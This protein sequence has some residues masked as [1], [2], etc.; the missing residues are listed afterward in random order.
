[1]RGVEAIKLKKL[2]I[3]YIDYFDQYTTTRRVSIGGATRAAKGGALVHVEGR[4]LG[5][6]PVRSIAHVCYGWAEPEPRQPAG[7]ADRRESL[8]E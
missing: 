8:A 2:H 6:R 5:K 3:Y 1:M 7:G 4:L